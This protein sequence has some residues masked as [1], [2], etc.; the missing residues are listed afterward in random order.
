MAIKIK[1]Y[2]DLNYEINF[3]KNDIKTLKEENFKLKKM[4]LEMREKIKGTTCP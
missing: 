1:N 2:D 3:I 4:I